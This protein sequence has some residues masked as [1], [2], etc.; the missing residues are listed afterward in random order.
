MAYRSPGLSGQLAGTNLVSAWPGV[1]L[2]S[3][4]MK[5]PWQ[6]RH[7]LPVLFT[8][9]VAKKRPA[10]QDGE[11]RIAG[12]VASLCDQ[13]G[14]QL[15]STTVSGSMLASIFA[16]DELQLN[17]YRAIPCSAPACS[18]SVN[19]AKAA[20]AEVPPAVHR[21]YRRPR[22]LHSSVGSRTADGS[23]CDSLA[24]ACMLQDV[25]LPAGG[26]ASGG[27]NHA[28]GLPVASLLADR[29]RRP[30]QG[31]LPDGLWECCA[32]E[33]SW[34]CR[35]CTTDS[36]SLWEV[37][38]DEDKR[39]ARLCEEWHAQRLETATGTET[40]RRPQVF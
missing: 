6:V 7:H 39:V 13:T 19:H 16:A 11:L 30:E 36:R 9:Q 22:L 20:Q 10:W 40:R 29:E 5:Q 23:S 21:P 2:A 4:N 38:V 31:A 17:G 3:D 28:H 25:K 18:P 8:G 35:T 26:H 15:E 12:G 14:R 24:A 1:A 27:S 32:A 34:Q 37:C 33:D